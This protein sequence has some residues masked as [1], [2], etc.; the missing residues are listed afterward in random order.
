MSALGGQR[1]LVT[2]AASGI[3]AATARLLAEAGAHVIC[4]DRADVSPV[5]SELQGNEGSASGLH[6][7]VADETSVADAFASVGELD[8]VVNSAGILIE[9]PLLTMPMSEVD[10]VFAVNLRGSF[11]VARG[12][13]SAIQSGGRLILIASELAHLGRPGY[14]AYCASKSGVIGL[15]RALARELAPRIL[16][17]CIAPGPTDTPMLGPDATSPEWLAKEADNPLGR[18]AQPAEIAAAALFLASPG[19]S[20]MTGQT[21]S[22]SGGAIM[23]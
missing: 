15:T 19:A 2:G 11:L 9:G 22:P 1:A 21:I 4:A 17:N 14:A 6:M 12:A 10:R 3:G 8:I 23:L 16:V 18:I 13:A 5:V 7:D 20:Y